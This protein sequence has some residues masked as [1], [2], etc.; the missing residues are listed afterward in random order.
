MKSKHLCTLIAVTAVSFLLSSAPRAYGLA[1]E[2]LNFDVEK[3][4]AEQKES[5]LTTKGQWG[6]V[7]TSIG[8]VTSAYICKYQKQ[9][10]KTTS[11]K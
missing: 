5:C 1:T 7:A 10:V 11:N 6:E 3:S 8:F 4:V 2:F 9:A